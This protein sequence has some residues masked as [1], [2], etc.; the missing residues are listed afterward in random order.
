MP[1]LPTAETQV[2]QPDCE[3]PISG[4][5]CAACVRRV[6]KALLKVPGVQAASVNLA[7]EYASIWVT[8]QAAVPLAGIQA[9]IENAGYA[10]G[11]P[12]SQQSEPVASDST[13]LTIHGVTLPTWWPVAL[14]GILSAPLALPMLGLLVGHHWM[15]NGWIQLLLA[16]A[17]Q[18]GLG[19]RFY[20]SAWKAVRARAGNMDLLVALG[21]SASFGLSVYTLIQPTA[22]VGMETPVYFDAAAMVITLVLLGKWLERR[23]K[24]ETTEA[25]RSLHALRPEWARVRRGAQ[26][27][28]IPIAQVTVGDRLVVRPGE[29]IPADGV[30]EMG[31]S[32]VDESLLTGESLPI[33]KQVGDSVTGGAINADGLLITRTTAI[34]A[35]STL[36][37][38]VRLVENAQ[39]KKAPIQKLVDRV[40]EVFVPVILLIAALTLM[41]WLLA[42]GDTARA[43]LNAVAV[44]VIACPCALGLATPTALMAGTGVAASNGIKIKDAAALETAHRTRVVV[45]DK[46]GT[47]TLGQPELRSALS[48]PGIA[49]ADLLRAA[50]SVQ[51]GSNHP[52]ARAVLQ[53][54]SLDQNGATIPDALNQRA[55]AGRGV[56]A[57]VGGQDLRLGSSTW[58]RELGVATDSLQS[59]AAA[60]EAQGQTISWLA[61]VTDTA[62]TAPRLLGLLAFGDTIRPTARTAIEQLRH[63]NIQVAMLTGD[64]PGSARAVATALGIDDFEANMLPASKAAWVQQ[65][66]ASGWVVAMVGDGINDAPALAAAD[67][68]LALSSGTD[69]AMHA[70]GITLLQGDP[71][72]VADAIRISRKTYTKIRQNLFWAFGYNA[73]GIP[74]AAFGWLNPMVAGAAMAFSSVSVVSNAL[75]LRRWRPE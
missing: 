40:S 69:V 70:A 43:V 52:L 42:T 53:A 31:A 73:I 41:G 60:F 50:A 44:L 16:S 38:I 3:L 51:S 67:I 59:Q 45:F 47:L 48:A 28:D 9:A 25:L 54:A 2:L 32:H 7:T 17:V 66:R 10:A 75:L 35:E 6:E 37:R 57:S 55:I 29:R 65:R 33:A 19:A 24:R 23:A 62:T 68:G 64:N 34:G 49:T 26:D 39:A 8:P 27:L 11:P 21:T 13:P 56:A 5:T 71:V 30:I 20:R 22:G 36:S 12:R 14:G 46:T 15:I 1:T 72:R 63:M 61:D 58:M 4:M 18:F 74:L